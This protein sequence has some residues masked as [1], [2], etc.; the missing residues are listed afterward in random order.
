MNDKS[1][2]KC[3]VCGAENIETECRDASIG[4]VEDYYHCENCSYF[5]KMSYSSVWRGIVE[6]FPKQ[7]SNKVRELNLTI[8][9][10]HDFDMGY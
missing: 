2:V 1:I 4:V 9:S 10:K 3:P 5:H 7:Y 8:V 6:G